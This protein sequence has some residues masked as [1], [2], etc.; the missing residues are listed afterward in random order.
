MAQG[1]LSLEKF[2]FPIGRHSKRSLL[3]L[4]RN[5]KH[6]GLEKAKDVPE[7]LHHLKFEP[8]THLCPVSCPRQ[9]S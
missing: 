2:S 4:K 1:C 8:R 3:K 7:R 6:H 5:M 9:I